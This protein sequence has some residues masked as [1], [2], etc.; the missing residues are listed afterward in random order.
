MAS[1]LESLPAKIRDDARFAEALARYMEGALALRQERLNQIY[2][3]APA[4]AAE[5]AAMPGK[6]LVRIV[7]GDSGS[8]AAYSFVD[9][10]TG[11]VYKPDGWKRPAK[12]ARSNIYSERNGLENHNWYGPEYLR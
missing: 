4:P 3:K 5:V 6:Q 1:I 12:H 2:T 7:M 8:S 11:D 9:I 10:A